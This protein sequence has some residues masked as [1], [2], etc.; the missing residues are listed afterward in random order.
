MIHEMY[1]ETTIVLSFL[2]KQNDLQNINYRQND[3]CDYITLEISKKSTTGSTYSSKALS[4]N[5]YLK[6]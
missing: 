3:I 6:I 4:I 1:F 2:K 5:I